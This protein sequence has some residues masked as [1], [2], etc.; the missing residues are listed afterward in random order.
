MR[1]CCRD[2]TQQGVGR[3]FQRNRKAAEGGQVIAVGDVRETC[4]HGVSD[5]NGKK[6]Q[7]ELCNGSERGNFARCLVNAVIRSEAKNNDAGVEEEGRDSA[8]AGNLRVGVVSTQPLDPFAALGGV[9]EDG[10]RKLPRADSEQWVLK[11]VDEADLE[12]LFS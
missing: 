3:H 12:E 1:S 6:A 7:S 9:G 8:F 11:G 5:Q 10:A 2:L 4:V